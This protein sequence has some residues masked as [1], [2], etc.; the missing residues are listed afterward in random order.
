[1]A[2]GS[3]QES[4]GHQTLHLGDCLDNKAWEEET[5]R[6]VRIGGPKELASEV[7]LAWGFSKML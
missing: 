7:C 3:E 2:C 4:E 5:V 6:A 1:M